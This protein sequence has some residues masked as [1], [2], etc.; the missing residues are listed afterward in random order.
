ML[1]HNFLRNWQFSAKKLAFFLKNQCYDQH[2]ALFSFL[3]SQKLQFFAELFREIIL[4]I[5]T[6]V[7]DFHLKQV[8]FYFPILIFDLASCLRRYVLK[9]DFRTSF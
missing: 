5:I 9:I 8:I 2:F 4:K 3:L 7:P 1:C 6:Y